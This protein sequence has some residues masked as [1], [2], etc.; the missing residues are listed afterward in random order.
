MAKKKTKKIKKSNKNK[1]YE[2]RAKII[3][4]VAAFLILGTIFIV[5]FVGIEDS[6]MFLGGDNLNE[7]GNYI[8]NPSY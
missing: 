3:V 8:N 2:H 4:S 1:L 7:L 6:L 5:A